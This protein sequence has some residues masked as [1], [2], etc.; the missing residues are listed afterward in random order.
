MRLGAAFQRARQRHCARIALQCQSLKRRA[1]GVSQSQNLGALVK[2][3]AQRIVD[4]RG[5]AAIAA[6]TLH[7]E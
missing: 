7:H 6:N 5:K 4:G 2:G 1:S 3:F